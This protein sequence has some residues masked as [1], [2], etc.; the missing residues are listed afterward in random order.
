MFSS[1]YHEISWLRNEKIMFKFKG[2]AKW[3]KP[4]PN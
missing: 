2:M 1:I 3:M 4:M